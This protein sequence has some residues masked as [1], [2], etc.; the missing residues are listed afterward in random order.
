[1]K[2]APSILSADFSRLGEQVAEAEQAGADYIHV[3]VM[4]GHFVPNLTIGPVVV[5][6]LRQRTKL[7]LDCHLMVTNPDMLIP[8]FAE[9]GANIITIHAEATPHVHR[10]IHYI[11]ERKVKAGI[12]INPSTPLAAIE[13]VL[14]YVDLVLI[15]TVNPGFGGQQFIESVL[16]KIQRLRAM[17]DEGGYVAELEVDGGVN[18]KTAPSV[19]KAGGRVLVAGT[20]I[21]NKRENVGAAMGRLK[22]SLGLAG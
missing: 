3:D 20:A 2:I 14:Q 18:E 9:A 16:P 1:M 12:S 21:Y 19:V 6:A 15:M 13:E 22:R 8:E 11:K 5:S 4:D 17:L 7:P 10:S